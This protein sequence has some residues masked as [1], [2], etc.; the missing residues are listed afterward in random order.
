MEGPDSLDSLEAAEL[1]RRTPGPSCVCV[2]LLEN[3]VARSRE[4]VV[5]EVGG[6][7][8]AADLVL[9]RPRLFSMAS[10]S[11]FLSSWEFITDSIWYY[12]DNP[13]DRCSGQDQDREQQRRYGQ[14]S[15]E[16]KKRDLLQPGKKNMAD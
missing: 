15:G 6:S 4:A 11:A 10:G 2:S 9:A 13:A 7:V 14:E 3:E 16:E 5:G 8:S 1:R 12:I